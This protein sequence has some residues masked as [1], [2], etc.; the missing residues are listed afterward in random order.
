MK[1]V[2]GII[3]AVYWLVAS[4][5]L[6]G[7]FVWILDTVSCKRAIQHSEAVQVATSKVEQATQIAIEAETKAVE[8][9]PVV[10]KAVENT[11][12]ATETRINTGISIEQLPM[13][14]QVEYNSMRGLIQAYETQLEHEISRADAWKTLTEAQQELIAALELDHTMALKKTYWQALRK[15]AVGGALVTLLVTV[16]L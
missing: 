5:A 8:A 1:T 4:A 12:K 3:K 7:F 6:V 10:V 9:R 14:V 11:R 13:P 2:K 15:G 16:I